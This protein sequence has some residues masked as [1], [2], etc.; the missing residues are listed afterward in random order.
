MVLKKALNRYRCRIG[1]RPLFYKIDDT[2]SIDLD[3][4]RDFKILNDLIKKER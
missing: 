3:N 1:K 4:E 2:E